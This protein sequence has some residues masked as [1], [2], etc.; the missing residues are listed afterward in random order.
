MY[1]SLHFLPLVTNLFLPRVTLELF[2]SLLQQ[3][4][5]GDPNPEHH[6]MDPYEAYLVVPVVVNGIQFIGVG[7]VTKSYNLPTGD[8]NDCVE[9]LQGFTSYWKNR[10]GSQDDSGSG[11][12]FL[13]SKI[14]G[15][16][17]SPICCHPG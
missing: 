11:L 1:S 13:M 16:G 17:L 5:F 15:H 3:R 6:T 9:F 2:N 8:A 14:S 10:T 12:V 4:A 7:I